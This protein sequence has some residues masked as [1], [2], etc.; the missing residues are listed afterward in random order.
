MRPGD[1]GSVKVCER[2]LGNVS[3]VQI[4][5]AVASHASW[6][7]VR[8]SCAVGILDRILEM[9]RLHA[10]SV[11]FPVSVSVCVCVYV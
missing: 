6:L 2:S 5:R 11:T 3:V 9:G 10:L 1:D 8:V 7:E 4:A